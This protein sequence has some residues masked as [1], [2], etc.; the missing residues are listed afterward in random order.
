MRH[1]D[2]VVDGDGQRGERLHHVFAALG[3]GLETDDL[4]VGSEVLGL[5]PADLAR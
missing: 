3:R 1:L 4:V 2:L 5:L